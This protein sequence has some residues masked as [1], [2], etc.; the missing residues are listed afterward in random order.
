MFLTQ[1]R[2]F[3]MINSVQSSLPTLY[4]SSVKCSMLKI[5]TSN[6]ETSV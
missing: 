2:K 6:L 3:L 5:S 4:M 1:G